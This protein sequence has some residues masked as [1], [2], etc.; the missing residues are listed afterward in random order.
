MTATVPEWITRAIMTHSH[1]ILSTTL[2]AIAIVLLI[3]LLLQKELLRARG[4]PRTRAWFS[5]LNVAIVPLLLAFGF[6][7]VTRLL[8][9]L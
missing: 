1:A 7:I 9:L 8:D 2:G 6:I 4:G 3:A 5:T